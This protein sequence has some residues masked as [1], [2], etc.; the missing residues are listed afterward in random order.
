MAVVPGAGLNVRA[1]YIKKNLTNK[2]R[3]PEAVG[4]V[5]LQTL[6]GSQY[7]EVLDPA[8]NSVSFGQ[9]LKQDSAQLPHWLQRKLT[10]SHH[11]LSCV[12]RGSVLLFWSKAASL[13]SWTY[14]FV[15]PVRNQDWH[16]DEGWGKAVTGCV[17]PKTAHSLIM[18]KASINTFL[19]QWLQR[20][21]FALLPNHYLSTPP[22]LPCAVY[23]S[24]LWSVLWVANAKAL[25]THLGE[26]K[27]L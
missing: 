5:S 22:E 3:T 23:R 7:K 9:I 17:P 15:V 16:T 4:Q 27:A 6:K 8:I 13:D 10:S 18:K 24:D 1:V 12:P 19:G 14:C 25:Q 21:S 11:L 26:N 2:R 20:S